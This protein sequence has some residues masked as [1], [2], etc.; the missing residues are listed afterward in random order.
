MDK[1][2]REVEGAFGLI[3]TQIHN[4][5]ALPSLLLIYLYISHTLLL[6]IVF[7]VLLLLYGFQNKGLCMFVLIF[8]S[9]IRE[10]QKPESNSL[11]TCPLKL[12]LILDGKTTRQY[13]ELYVFIRLIKKKEEE[14]NITQ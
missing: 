12:I 9:Y 7:F 14:K 2:K 13:L 4:R 6:H 10:R 5:P 8:K 3:C 1:I 11:H